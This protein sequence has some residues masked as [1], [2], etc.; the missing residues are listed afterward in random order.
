MRKRERLCDPPTPRPPARPLRPLRLMFAY[1]YCLIFR[2]GW[3][4]KFE[5]QRWV[6][7]CM[8]MHVE[9]KRL[10]S[11]CLKEAK[12]VREEMLRWFNHLE[13]MNN[14]E[15]TKHI[16]RA[17]VCNGWVCKSHRRKFYGDK[18]GG[19]ANELVCKV[20][21]ISVKQERYAKIVSCGNLWFLLT[22]LGNRRGFI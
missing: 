10:R 14:S 22:L 2:T 21:K 9:G 12:I 7:C 17:N 13:N 19:I 6:A 11:W 8:L 18:S 1:D 4:N 20:S 5:G 15:L 16:N 3:K